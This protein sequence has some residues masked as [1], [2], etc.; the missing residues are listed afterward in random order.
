MHVMLAA[1]DHWITGCGA[2]WHPRR[3]RCRPPSARHPTPPFPQPIPSKAKQSA[4]TMFLKMMKQYLCCWGTA[5]EEIRIEDLEATPRLQAPSPVYNQSQL[6]C[7]FMRIQPL[8]PLPS[9]RSSAASVELTPSSAP[10]VE[11]TL[12]PVPRASA[13]SEVEDIL[14]DS[15]SSL[16]T[17]TQ[18][19]VHELRVSQA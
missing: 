7:S 3:R 11:G 2:R 12:P 16:S 6:P 17:T 5:D 4:R 10:A 1:L 14:G 8:P 9:P 19:E 15:L 13:T 18:Q